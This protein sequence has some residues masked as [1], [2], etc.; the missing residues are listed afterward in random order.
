MVFSVDC[1]SFSHR[2]EQIARTIQ[3]GKKV[4]K[5]V[6]DGEQIIAEYVNG[7]LVREY[8]YGPGIDEPILMID[9]VLGDLYF[10]HY[11]GLGSVVALVDMN[12]QVVEKYSYDAF[13]ACTV[14]YRGSDGIWN[15]A[16][17][18]TGPTPQKGNP[19]LF[20]GR[21]YD[22]ET[23]LYYYRARMYSPSLGR[24][25][26][27]D[28]IG[29]ADSMNLY[30]YCGNNP[31]N[32]VDPMGQCRKEGWPKYLS[33]EEFQAE[34]SNMRDELAGRIIP[35]P[36]FLGAGLDIKEFYTTDPVKMYYHING[37]DMR[38]VH[39]SDLNYYSVGMTAAHF[40]I[41]RQWAVLYFERYKI[42]RYKNHNPNPNIYHYFNRG[43]DEY[44]KYRAERILESNSRLND[45][46]QS[47]PWLD[48]ML[49]GP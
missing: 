32:F 29:Y 16:D 12:G 3:S 19:F 1:V 30:G 23:G 28:P 8:I 49:Q 21:Q 24:F 33:E 31:I 2:K 10:Y 17:D 5:C 9:M 7:T 46:I 43:Y 41:P 42:R 48:F 22:P 27:T 14:L 20:T 40:G 13:G 15:T 36:M 47:R 6:Y 35:W 34:M 26:Q 38:Y 18:Y 37:S 44:P 4:M 45:Y 25:L 11:D 39:G